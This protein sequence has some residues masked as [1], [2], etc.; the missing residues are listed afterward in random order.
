MAI[1]GRHKETADLLLKEIKEM[2][3]HSKQKIDSRSLVSGLVS[4]DPEYY[5]RN[6]DYRK[7]DG[8][9]IKYTADEFETYIADLMKHPT[10][11]DG[12]PEQKRR[13]C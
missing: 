6:A 12:G 5:R 13:R 3:E 2:K 11:D 1:T 7:R 9:L 4:R 8:L 10:D